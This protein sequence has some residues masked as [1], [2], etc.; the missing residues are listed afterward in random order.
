M[1]MTPSKFGQDFEGTPSMTTLSAALANAIGVRGGFRAICF[2][3]GMSQS[4]VSQLTADLLELA[5]R[6]NAAESYAVQVG[7]ELPASH[8]SRVSTRGVVGYR[9]HMRVFIWIERDF[10]P[11]SSFLS[12]VPFVLDEVFPAVE[13][14]DGLTISEIAN[15]LALELKKTYEPALLPGDWINLNSEIETVLTFYRDA[16]SLIETETTQ[17]WT[18]SWWRLLNG[19]VSNLEIELAKESPSSLDYQDLI[20]ASSRLPIPTNIN[21]WNHLTAK[22]FVSELKKSWSSESDAKSSLM[23]LSTA[24]D[25]QQED[26]GLHFLDWSSFDTDLRVTQNLVVSYLSLNKSEAASSFNPWAEITEKSFL[27]LSESYEEIDWPPTISLYSGTLEQSDLSG[28]INNPIYFLPTCKHSVVEVGTTLEIALD[29]FEVAVDI[30]LPSNQDAIESLSPKDFIVTTFNSSLQI[31]VQGCEFEQ[32]A[33]RL[34]L[35]PT[36][37]F[38]ASKNWPSKLEKV[39]IKLVADSMV[40]TIPKFKTDGISIQLWLPSPWNAPSFLFRLVPPR[41]KGKVQVESGGKFLWDGSK[42]TP[43]SVTNPESIELKS[44]CSANVYTLLAGPPTIQIKELFVA[45]SKG[46]LADSGIYTVEGCYLE[47]ESSIEIELADGTVEQLAI[48]EI[49]ESSNR[50][51]SPILA[52]SWGV[53]PR[54]LEDTLE[55]QE[56]DSLLGSLESCFSRMFFNADIDV[57]VSEIGLGILVGTSGRKSDWIEPRFE[58]GQPAIATSNAQASVAITNLGS[59]LSDEVLS[60]EEFS[61]FWKALIEIRD[62]LG[63]SVVSARNRWV[64]RLSIAHIEKRQVDEFL[65]AY[66]KLVELGDNLGN[67][68]ELWTRYPFSMQIKN[69]ISAKLEGILLS[70]LHPIRF[71]WFYGA[72]K[73]AQASAKSGSGL[74]ADLVQVIDGWNFP[75]IGPGP[76]PGNNDAILS[77]FPMAQGTDQ[78]FATWGFLCSFDNV[79]GSAPNVPNWV[80]G[81]KLPA[82]AITGLTAGGF[83]AAIKDYLRVNPQL[84]TL[85]IDLASTAPSTRSQEIDNALMEETSA[86]INKHKSSLPGGIRIYDSLNR[87]GL[88]PEPERLIPPRTS[89]NSFGKGALTW[90]RYNHTN[91]PKSD[92]RFFENSQTEL[93]RVE[94]EERGAFSY[95]PVRRFSPRDTVD[96]S[97]IQGSVSSQACKHGWEA[98]FN[99]LKCLEAPTGKSWALKTSQT[100]PDSQ[101]LEPTNWVVT[102][103]TFID[104]LELSVQVSQGGRMLWE[105]RPGMLGSATKHGKHHLGTR[106]YVTVANIPSS[107]ER[108]LQNQ[109]SISPARSRDVIETL[110]RRGI[111]L[112]SLLAIG[113]AH[114]SGALG[115]YLAYKVLD[116]CQPPEGVVRSIVPIDAID[117]V[118][119]TLAGRDAT[120]STKRAD[121]LVIDI[122]ENNGYHVTLTPVEVKCYPSRINAFPDLESSGVSSAVDQLQDSYQVISG[123][124]ENTFGSVSS[125]KCDPLTKSLELSALAGVIEIGLSLVSESASEKLSSNVLTACLSGN[126]DFHISRG[127]LAWFQ[128][129]TAVDERLTFC[130][131]RSAPL[132]HVGTLFA[133]IQ[134]ILESI[135]SGASANQ[136]ELVHYLAEW[137]TNSDISV[138]QFKN[139]E[140]QPATPTHLDDSGKRDEPAESDEL[141]PESRPERNAPSNGTSIAGPKLATEIGPEQT[142]NPR[143]LDR[144]NIGS[145]DPVVKLGS[146]RSG[147]EIIWRPLKPEKRLNNSHCVILGSSGSGKTQTIKVFVSELAKQGLVP[148]LL[149][150]KDDFVDLDFRQA[151]GAEFYDAMEGL[152]FNPLRPEVDPLNNSIH[153][154]KQAMALSG[155][156]KK[157]F[158][159]GDQQENH[160]RQA[161]YSAFESVGVQKLDKKLGPSG[162][163][164]SFGSVFEFLEETGDQQLLNRISPIFELALFDSS[165]RTLENVFNTPSIIRL[166]QLP[167]EEIKKAV[168]E[169]VLRS[170]YNLLLT[171]GHS[172]KLKWVIVVD[173]AHKIANLDSL[174]ILLKEARA[175]GVSI[176][177]SSQEA[178]DFDDSV[179]ANSGTIITMK[180]SETKDSERVAMLLGG[181]SVRAELG[182][183]L[184]SLHTF[185][186]MIKNDHYSG[187]R[188]YF[189]FMVNPYYQRVLDENSNE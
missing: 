107:F 51:W 124:L 161:I 130:W 162:E 46:Y 29:E 88:V 111:G 8:P 167:N 156:F 78:I 120:D 98:F 132:N 122:F 178:K 187:S 61:R 35:E 108:A 102:G 125:K 64:S 5:V 28:G 30:D 126:I 160:L 40:T 53:P 17:S 119:R 144:L 109:T 22:K 182:Q 54:A 189:Q 55:Q 104:P 180:L 71:A 157:V 163:A 68:Q 62:Q 154:V 14:S 93:S 85:A 151:V 158:G 6:E 34:R 47:D 115:F 7:D 57:P 49:E 153:V 103:N 117:V 63:D 18:T 145:L 26:S 16:L 38:S 116:L 41:G 99:A 174:R 89:E 37:Q 138:G 179:F 67:G 176:I 139:P 135:E 149:D 44:E 10:E 164:P 131:E 146:D 147:H 1:P 141:K 11:D 90:R 94:G 97:I 172:N 134:W 148:I 183:K 155:I 175:F 181:S 96:R 129:S 72:Q 70:P 3:L 36:F 113:G 56:L 101:Q 169:L 12:S 166:T 177:L 128:N 20:Y 60:S 142:P 137:I 24:D 33:L 19:F 110:G 43:E 112:A 84:T 75:W 39:N 136:E 92:I 27:L 165:S 23:I 66:C 59:S 173:E 123:A 118:F 106:P 143:N 13:K 133:D 127:V 186:A 184:R 185:D 77:A 188:G 15:H 171:K 74:A 65:E 45:K 32:R 87:T 114:S 42:L 91:T 4:F 159:L 105:W 86:Y 31:A 95:W 80:C 52:H 76:A 121:L 73:A 82:G 9:N 152:P 170:L 2:P 140:S 168:A 58:G 100:V 21:G 69:D 25:F 81:K 48:V 150:F 83:A 79:Q 50:P